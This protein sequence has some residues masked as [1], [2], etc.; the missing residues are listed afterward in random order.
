LASSGGNRVKAIEL[1]GVLSQGL[2][3]PMR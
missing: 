3:W 2:C 1:R